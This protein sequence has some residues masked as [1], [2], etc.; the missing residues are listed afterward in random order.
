V[1][2]TLEDLAAACGGGRRVAV[3]RELTKLHEEVWRGSLAD[4]ARWAAERQPPGEIVLVVEGAPAPTPPGDD[5]LAAALRDLIGGGESPRD[6]A[7]AVAA[8]F[9]V[10]KRRAY[11][12]A[13]TVG[14]SSP[15]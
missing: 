9:G 1:A 14:R 15:A 2:R 5:E 6:A 3:A 13:V 10:P 8:R 11:E 12:L 7:A 4:A